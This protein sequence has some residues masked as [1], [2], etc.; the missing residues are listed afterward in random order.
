MPTEQKVAAVEEME[1]LLKDSKAVYF[2]DFSGIDVPTFTDLR[3]QLHSEDV[4]FTVVKN[5]LAKIAAANAGIEGLDDALNGPT[6]MVCA[7]SDPIAPARLLSE[8]A[9]KADGKPKV[10]LG[11]MEGTVYVEEQVAA[12]AK[13]PT[14]EVLLTQVVTGLQSPISGLAICLSGILQSLV[15][16]IQAV[17]DKKKNEGGE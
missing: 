7:N 3:R 10:K 11:Y 1:T 13:L 17:A 16:T 12:L 5:R 9:E 6:G 2:A 4:T 14:R 15:G 8:F